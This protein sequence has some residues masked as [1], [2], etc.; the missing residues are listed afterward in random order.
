[1]AVSQPNTSPFAAEHS[2]LTHLDGGRCGGVFGGETANE[3]PPLW[4]V[5]A[6]GSDVGVGCG[7]TAAG[8]EGEGK[9]SVEASGVVGWVDRKKRN[10]FG[11]RRKSPP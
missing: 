9:K 10:T 7:G 5:M 8:E 1:M 4:C 2:K 11:V 6:R 3:Q